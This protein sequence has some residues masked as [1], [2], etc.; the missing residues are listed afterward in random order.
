MKRNATSIPHK[1]Y[2]NFTLLFGLGAQLTHTDDEAAV[3]SSVRVKL[4]GDELVGVEKQS[5]LP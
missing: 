4:T 5:R 1:H 2:V 3:P